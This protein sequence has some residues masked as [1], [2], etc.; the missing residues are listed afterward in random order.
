MMIMI[1]RNISI[2]TTM[3]AFFYDNLNDADDDN[4]DDDD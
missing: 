1:M 3:C 2:S 4:D